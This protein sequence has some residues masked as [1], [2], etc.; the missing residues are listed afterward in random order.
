MR[1]TL[2][3][4][5]DGTVRQPLGD[6]KFIQSPDD[7][8]LIKGASEAINYFAQ[9]DY[10]IIG[11]TNQGGVA[12][13]YKTLEKC[14]EEQKRTIALCPSILKIYFCPDFEG[15]K[16]GCVYSD[17]GRILNLDYSSE[18][19]DIPNLPTLEYDSFRKPGSGMIRYILD[20]HD[21]NPAESIYV[22]DRQE[23][24]DCVKE[25][26]CSFLW[27]DFWRSSFGGEK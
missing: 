2:V 9:R 21:I 5:M 14:I 17:E 26:N 8:S 11:C 23:D 20:T 25:I 10:L 6:N 16:I 12:A 15:K 24:R 4:D 18:D 19:P 1:R 22:G 13:G 3:L 27:A 7:Q